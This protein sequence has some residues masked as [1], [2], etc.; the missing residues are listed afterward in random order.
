MGLI[1]SVWKQELHSEHGFLFLK[2][3]INKKTR[4]VIEKK[5][6]RQNKICH[7]VAPSKDFTIKPPKLK[8]QAPRNINKGPG[9]F[10]MMFIKFVRVNSEFPSH[11]T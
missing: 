8:L 7:K 10:V 3:V 6:D 1:D 5:T 2:V 11:T 4:T 9:S